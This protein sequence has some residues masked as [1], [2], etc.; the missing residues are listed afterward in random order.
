MVIVGAGP[1]GSVAAF[2][3]KRRNPRLRV[4]LTDKAVFP[5]DKA[6]GDGLGAGAVAALRRLGLLGVV[7]DAISPLSV[8]VSGPDG[9]EATAVGPTVA[10]RDLSGYVLP[11]EIL[12]ARLVAAAREV[13]VEMRE[14]TS[15]HSSEL[16]GNSRVITFKTGSRSNSVEA[17]LMIG[18]DGAYSR[19]RRDLGVGRQDDR[20][21]SIAMR[22]YAK[23][24]DPR[25]APQEV[26]P[27]RLDFSDK[28]LPGYGWVFPVSDDVG[29]LG[30]GLPVSTMREKSLNPHNL[31]SAYVEDLRA[32]GFIV[33]E[34]NK[35]LSHYLPHAGKLAPMAHPRA[36][37]IG[38][39]AAS[40]N[41]LSGEGIVYAMVAAEMLAA[42]LEGWNGLGHAELSGGLQLFEQKFRRRFRLHFA[43]C[44]VAN[45]LMGH[46]R[47]ANLVIRAASRD[48]H[49][50]DAAS[51]MLFD[52]RRMYLSTGARILIRGTR[53]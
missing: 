6:C 28:V 39:A 14:G 42:A 51:L 37:L 24:S 8:R 18:A 41:P 4:L 47:W 23:F 26:M 9:T 15:Y 3:L 5:R 20:F 19:V 43:S 11:R 25:R 30:V 34:P 50:M 49:V 40:I 35:L 10:G 13:G 29:N 32:R 46:R 17:A 27:L 12:D 44:T 31:L 22:S 52:E 36:A 53:R 33:E 1:A 38:D 48:S 45:I 2:A 7:H 16:T 21:S